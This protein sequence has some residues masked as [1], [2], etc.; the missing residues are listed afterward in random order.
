MRGMKKQ[1]NN[2]LLDY[3]KCNNLKKKKRILESNNEMP[4]IVKKQEDNYN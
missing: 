2:L 1:L 4:N 3:K